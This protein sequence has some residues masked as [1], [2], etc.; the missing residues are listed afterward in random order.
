MDHLVE[1]YVYDG[2]DESGVALLSE[3]CIG[4]IYVV[5]GA[6]I[7]GSDLAGYCLSSLPFVGIP[8]DDRL[9][10]LVDSSAVVFLVDVHSG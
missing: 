8:T 6:Q 7:A 2:L 1:C 5:S 9:L 4:L 3:L 10:S